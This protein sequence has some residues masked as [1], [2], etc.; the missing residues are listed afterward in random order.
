LSLS[1][2]FDVAGPYRYQSGFNVTAFVALALGIAVAMVGNFFPQLDFL[3]NLSWF[4]GF[5]TSLVVYAVA[6]RKS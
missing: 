1:G 3:Y 5:G 2:L 6:M 4:T